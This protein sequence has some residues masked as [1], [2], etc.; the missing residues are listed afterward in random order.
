MCGITI[1]KEPKRYEKRGRSEYEKKNRKV[2]LIIPSDSS[3]CCGKIKI[4]I[5]F[6]LYGVV[7]FN[8]LIVYF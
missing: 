4:S 1:F 2:Y 3:A 6:F 8:S 7:H 5:P